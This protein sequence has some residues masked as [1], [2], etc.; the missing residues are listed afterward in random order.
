M[1]AIQDMK[2]LVEGINERFYE[3]G[4]KRRIV[5]RRTSD[6]WLVQ[7][8]CPDGFRFDLFKDTQRTMLVWL[9]AYYSG[10]IVPRTP[11]YSL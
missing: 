2:D 8:V 1:K 11:C 3:L 7:A 6:K 10:L 9:R 5:I 4:D